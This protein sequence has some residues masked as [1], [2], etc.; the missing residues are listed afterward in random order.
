MCLSLHHCPSRRLGTPMILFRLRYFRSSACGITTILSK[1]L[2]SFFVA[3]PKL[4]LGT[5]VPMAYLPRRYPMWCVYRT[6]QSF[7]A[8]S[9]HDR[10]RA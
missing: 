9:L 6:R 5:Q 2:L 8:K 10:S 1:E 3:R 7:S 4:R